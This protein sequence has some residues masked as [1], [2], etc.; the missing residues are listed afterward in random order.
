MRRS[1]LW[2]AAAACLEA[3]FCFWVSACACP[4]A[5]CLGKRAH[6]S[7]PLDARGNAFSS[8]LSPM[9]LQEVHFFNIRSNFEKGPAFYLAHFGASSCTLSLRRRS[10]CLRT[11]V[12]HLRHPISTPHACAARLTPCP[13][14]GLDP[15]CDGRKSSETRGRGAAAYVDGTPTYLRSPGAARRLHDTVLYPCV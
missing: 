14:P 12:R 10:I 1:R 9:T 8:G 6:P 11:T 15:K 4:A 2:T 3:C 7:A 5:A 13:L